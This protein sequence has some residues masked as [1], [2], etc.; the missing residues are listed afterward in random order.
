MH[1]SYRQFAGSSSRKLHE[2][3]YA[4]IHINPSQHSTMA[5]SSPEVST[6]AC[7][8]RQISII[9]CLFDDLPAYLTDAMCPSAIHN[10]HDGGPRHHDRTETKNK[11]DSIDDTRRSLQLLDHVSQHHL[12]H[13]RRC[14]THAEKSCTMS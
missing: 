8:S 5:C 7:Y 3:T 9:K 11:P 2:Y 12:P 14:Q 4:H 6:T 13:Q 1:K 10:R